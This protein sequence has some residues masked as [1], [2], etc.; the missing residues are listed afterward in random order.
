MTVFERPVV[1]PRCNREIQL[2]EGVVNTEAAPSRGDWSLCY[3]CGGVAIF[4]GEPLMLRL[5]NV[6]E[7]PALR[8]NPQVRLALAVWRDAVQLQP[9]VLKARPR[10]LHY[11]ARL[12][13]GGVG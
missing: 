10:D 5:P 3:Y 11:I 1:C 13:G 8:S 6:D 9:E 12:R 7:A 4:D 2:H